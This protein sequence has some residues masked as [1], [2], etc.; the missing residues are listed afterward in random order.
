MRVLV[1]GSNGMLG[2]KVVEYFNTKAG[3]TVIKD[4]LR[5]D[6]YNHISYVNY[7]NDLKPDYVIN[8]IGLIKQKSTDFSA[9]VMLNSFLPFLIARSI[10]A[11]FIHA[12]TD[13]VFSGDF[14]SKKDIDSIPDCIDDYGI[15]KYFGELGLLRLSN[16]KII[17]ASIIGVTENYQSKGLMDWFAKTRQGDI[18]NGFVNHL[19]NGI[20]T[21]TWCEICHRIILGE[22][23]LNIIQAGT[24]EIYSKYDMLNIFS[25]FF[26][27][28]A[29]VIPFSDVNSID[30]SLEPNYFVDSLEIQMSNYFRCS[31]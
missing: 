12:S 8:C 13:C 31:E 22:I 26:P 20:T 18:V 19:W 10:K 23:S 6:Y 17:R 29:D 1:L 2:Q 9:L 4:S 25:K 24:K 7:I 14:N 11:K 16:A 27:G 5:F 15:S 28:T 21:L 3:F 30:R